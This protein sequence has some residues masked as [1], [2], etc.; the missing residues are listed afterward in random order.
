MKTVMTIL[1]TLE[2]ASNSRKSVYVVKTFKGYE[3]I[4][5]KVEDT[6]NMFTANAGEQT[7]PFTLVTSDKEANVSV[8]NSIKGFVTINPKTAA[9]VGLDSKVESIQYKNYTIIKNGELH[10]EE[11]TVN[12][13]NVTLT[14]LKEINTPITNETAIDDNNTQVVINFKGLEIAESDMTDEEVV[15]LVKELN[16]LKIEEKAIKALQPKIEYN[17]TYTAE[18]AEALAEYGVKD[19]VYTYIAPKSDE[20]PSTYTTKEVLYQIKGSASIP[21]VDSVLKKTPTKG[22]GLELYNKYNELNG[23]TEDALATMAKAVKAKIQARKIA[24]ANEKIAYINNGGQTATIESEEAV[25]NIK[26]TE[27]EKSY[28]AN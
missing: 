10:I 11:L 28:T 21:S 14:E 12:V 24:L 1:R 27:K 3:R 23:K 15:S 4:G 6:F 17:A 8:R 5:V 25:L 26:V 18:Q 7:T 9:R 16:S 13:D 20:T 2:N 19:G 22:I